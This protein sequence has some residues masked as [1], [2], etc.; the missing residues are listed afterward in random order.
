MSPLS[1]P[2]A[3]GSGCAP[4]GARRAGSGCSRVP[5]QTSS[6]L[7]PSRVIV[8]LLLLIVATLV[9]GPVGFIVMGSLL[10]VWAIVTGTLHLVIDLLLLPFR[11][12]GELRRS[13]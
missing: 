6:G 4:A 1:T 13:R 12:V 5:Q 9:L 2:A 3:N 7:R 8:A 10:L 11:A